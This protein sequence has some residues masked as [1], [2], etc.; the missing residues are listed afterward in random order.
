MTPVKKEKLYCSNSWTF[1]A[2]AHYE[3]M[4]AIATKGT[5]Y[6]LAEQYGYQCDVSSLSCNSGNVKSHLY[7]FKENGVPV[8]SAYPFNLIDKYPDICTNTAGRVK[9]NQNIL[10]S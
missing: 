3:S 8:E 1:A 2:I 5:I 6:D 10:I 4:L 9:I 7:L